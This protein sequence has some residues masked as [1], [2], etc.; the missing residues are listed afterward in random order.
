VLRAVV[1]EMDRAAGQVRGVIVRA[2]AGVDA[3]D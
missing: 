2:S 1:R 3:A